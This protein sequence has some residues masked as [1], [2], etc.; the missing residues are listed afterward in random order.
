M[1]TLAP[2]KLGLTPRMLDCLNAIKAHIARYGA[3][4]AYTDLMVALD[5]R[6]K[7]TINRLVYA[8]QARGWIIFREGLNRTIAIVPD[9]VTRPYT[10]PAEVE[11]KLLRHC[12]ATNED[13]ADVLADAVALFL[14]E[15]EGSIAA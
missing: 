5:V 9:A 15:A 10:L 11:A 3:A 2:G 12:C 6:S 13:P 8:L 4:P 14:D 7:G 1:N